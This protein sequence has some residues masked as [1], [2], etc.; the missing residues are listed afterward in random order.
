M[1]AGSF[2]SLPDALSEGNCRS[3]C[4]IVYT[5]EKLRTSAAVSRCSTPSPSSPE[6]PWP[7]ARSAPRLL[8][9]EARVAAGTRSRLS[10]GVL[11][12]STRVGD[13]R[14]CLRRQQ[15]G[16]KW[17]ASAH[18][19]VFHDSRRPLAVQAAAIPLTADHEP[20]AHLVLKTTMLSGYAFV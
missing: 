9:D 11:A 1:L 15:S 18:E 8:R 5:R 14:R 7:P 16:D 4:A 17:G 12:R 6:S 2:R 20:A 13:P 19:K 10:R 3:F